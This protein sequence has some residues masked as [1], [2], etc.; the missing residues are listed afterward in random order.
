MN[1]PGPYRI[2]GLGNLVDQGQSVDFTFNGNS[3]TGF[4]GDSLASALLANGIRTVARSFKFHRPRGIFSCGFEEPN[5]L[6]QL[7]EGAAAIP[8]VR[9][10]LVPLIKGIQARSQAGWPSASFDVLRALDFIAPLFAAG[11]YNKTFMWPSWH[12][13]EP[14]I[15][16]T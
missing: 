11:F 14:I 10:P 1:R 4:T 6:L 13:Y 12:T 3:Y 9:A 5:G 16:R 8:S 15:R 2:S 7:G